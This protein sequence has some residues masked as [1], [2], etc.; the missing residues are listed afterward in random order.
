MSA[1]RESQFEYDERLPPPVSETAVEIA[2]RD[3]IDNAVETLVDRRSDVKFKRRLHAAQGVTFKQFA[4]E[5]EQFAVNSAS[6]SPCA[7]GEMVIAGLLGD[8]FLARDGAEDLMAVADPK[9]QLRAIAEGLLR[10]LVNDAL[11]AQ[12]EDNEL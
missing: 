3:W 10:P 6:K 5:V 7:I 2:G 9:E 11:V 1:L 8:R 12:A 4:A